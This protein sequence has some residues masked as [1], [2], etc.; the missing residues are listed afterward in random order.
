MLDFSKLAVL[1][2]H[3]ID[4]LIVRRATFIVRIYVLQKKR[5]RDQK[6]A[7]NNRATHIFAIRR[8]V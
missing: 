3:A 6:A 1:C 4:L 7:C 8:V 2:I 5:A